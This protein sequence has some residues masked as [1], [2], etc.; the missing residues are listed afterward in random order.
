LNEGVEVFQNRSAD[1]TDILHEYFVPD[2]AFGEFVV[3]LRDIIPRHGGNLLNLT[4]RGIEQ[5]NDTLLRYA[6]GPMLS[7]VMLF[8]QERDAAGEAKMAAM[9]RDLVDAALDAGGCYYLPYRLHATP[10]QFRRAYPR[11]DSFFA[12]KRKF[13]PDQVFQNQFYLKY[14]AQQRE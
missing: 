1:S 14:G 9:T 12:L 11:C 6:D 5:D 4:V 8:Y 3:Q 7:L 10:E 13:D 2:A